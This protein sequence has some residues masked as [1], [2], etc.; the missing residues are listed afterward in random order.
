MMI[1]LS[2]IFAV[3][4]GWRPIACMAPLPMPPS[5]IPEPIAAMPM[6]M[7]RPRPSAAW[8]SI[9]LPPSGLVGVLRFP[10]MRVLVVRQHEEDV[11][12]AQHREHERLQGAREKRQEHERKLEG[13]ADRHVYERADHHAEARECDEQ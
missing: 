5:P 2:W 12:R 8:K 4:S 9:V 6:P 11:D 10:L 7:G 13:H 3:A 1:M